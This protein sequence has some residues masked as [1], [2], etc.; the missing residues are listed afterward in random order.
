VTSG[1]DTVFALPHKA[2]RF[3]G[4][5]KIPENLTDET[6]RRCSQRTEAQGFRDLRQSRNILP[7]TVVTGKS[8]ARPGDGKMVIQ[9]RV[10]LNMAKIIFTRVLL[11]A[12]NGP[13]HPGG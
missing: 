7:V 8:G 3:S 12:W 9:H 4:I 10:P 6:I 11:P 1:F 5:E 13:F 2:Q